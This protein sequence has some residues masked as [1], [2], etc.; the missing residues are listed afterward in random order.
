M[1]DFKPE[2]ST[3]YINKQ[4]KMTY[5]QRQQK[6]AAFEKERAL[7]FKDTNKPL[8]DLISKGVLSCVSVT[9]SFLL[10]TKN[11]TLYYANYNV[12]ECITKE[13]I[14]IYC[15]NDQCTLKD[16]LCTLEDKTDLPISNRVA[17]AI[18]K[19]LWGFD[20]TNY[21][22]SVNVILIKELES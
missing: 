13:L 3:L 11:A 7:L 21:H 18:S 1:I 14:R 22:K 8:Y 4:C 2:E 10:D 20:E 12:T 6:Q 17:L 16:I 19:A 5:V 9:Q 15:L